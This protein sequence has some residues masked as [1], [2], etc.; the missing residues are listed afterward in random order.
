[1]KKLWILN[2]HSGLEGDRH[3]ELAKELTHYK[4]EVVVFLSSFNHG[5]E[6]Y[7]YEE[8]VKIKKICPGITYVY[9]HTAPAYHGISAQRILNM[10]SYCWLMRKYE[11]QFYRLFG[12]PDMVI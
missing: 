3:Y 10:M 2:H 6:Q 7:T 11:P 8:E 12:Q 1:M 9:L 4:I 5:C